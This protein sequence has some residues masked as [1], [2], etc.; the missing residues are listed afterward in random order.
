MKTYLRLLLV[1]GILTGAACHDKQVERPVPK[2]ED[3]CKVT[4]ITPSSSIPI[5]IHFNKE[6]KIE[7][8]IK[9]STLVKISYK[10]DSV[11]ATELI[12][13]GSF[14]QTRRYKIGANGYPSGI[15]VETDPTGATWVNYSIEYGGNER[16]EISKEV[17]TT[18]VASFKI[19]TVYHWSDGNLDSTTNGTN[20]IRYSY[21][22]DKVF[23]VGDASFLEAMRG[24][25]GIFRYRTRNM[26]K[27]AQYDPSFGA[28]Y[29]VDYRYTY[30]KGG[31]VTGLKE[32]GLNYEL[33]YQCD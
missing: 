21:F 17:V 11:L 19:I 1:T 27:R 20:T 7:S 13:N 33:Q 3:P 16:T 29:S 28:G 31:K 2:Q 30:G 4:V 9:G 5:N 14:Y 12:N 15:R 10:G 26:R 8:I 32:G 22:T 18:S 24:G 6:G 23:Q 25:D